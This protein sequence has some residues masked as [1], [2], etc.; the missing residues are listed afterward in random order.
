[1]E[2][3]RTK[4]AKPDSQH[5]PGAKT[6]CLRLEIPGWRAAT[7]PAARLRL[8]TQPG[9]SRAPTLSLGIRSQEAGTPPVP[10]SWAAA[11]PE[12]P[13]HGGSVVPG[14]QRPHRTGVRNPRQ[15]RSERQGAGI[16]RDAGAGPGPGE[17]EGKAS[18]AV[19]RPLPAG[20][21]RVPGPGD[22]EHRES[23]AGLPPRQTGAWGPSSPRPRDP[24]PLAPKGSSGAGGRARHAGEGK[25][26]RTSDGQSQTC[27]DLAQTPSC[28]SGFPGQARRSCKPRCG[29]AAGA[30]GP[31]QD[32][33]PRLQAPEGTLRVDLVGEL[34][35]HEDALAAPL[36]HRHANGAAADIH[37]HLEAQ[38]ERK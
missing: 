33:L 15:D 1:M 34:P 29:D 9:A 25:V 17:S 14:R 30:A 35:L 7:R 32:A 12:P 26:S 5:N 11:A 37:R 16:C 27:P 28:C 4:A 3:E 22:G 8:R 6:R 31:Y 21:P 18:T 23:T 13:W 36:Q 24:L 2:K 38:G 10:R 20:R 19:P